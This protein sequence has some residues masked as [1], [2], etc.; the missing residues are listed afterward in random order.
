MTVNVNH[1]EIAVNE[2]ANLVDLLLSMDIPQKGVALAVN[3]TVVP[4]NDWA[5]FVLEQN[6]NITLIRATQGG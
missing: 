6:M 2:S 4:K 3:N 5:T 1:K